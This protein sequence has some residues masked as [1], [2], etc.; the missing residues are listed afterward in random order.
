MP[1]SK[2][3]KPEEKKAPSLPE[4]LGITDNRANLIAKKVH[5]LLHKHENHHSV[6]MELNE[7]LEDNELL[8]A[9][10]VYGRMVEGHEESND[11]I[12]DEVME[13]LNQALEGLGDFFKRFGKENK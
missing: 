7:H 3:T 8:Y 11:E 1:F 13:E 12:P 9:A 6:L 5:F 10:Y 2:K 4:A